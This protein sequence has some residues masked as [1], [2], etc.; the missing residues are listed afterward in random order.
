MVCNYYYEIISATGRHTN[1]KPLKFWCSSLVC[2][3]FLFLSSS[4]FF[5]V[6]FYVSVRSFTAHLVV[7]INLVWKLFKRPFCTTT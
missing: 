5:L 1:A 7:T 6:S 3:C 4:F 2:D